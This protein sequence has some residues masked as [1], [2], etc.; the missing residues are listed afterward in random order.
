MN[1][2][3]SHV[4]VKCP[5]N[6]DTSVG[7]TLLQFVQI[8]RIIDRALQNYLYPIIA[9]YAPGRLGQPPH[10]CAAGSPVV[11]ATRIRP[12]YVPLC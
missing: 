12:D 5:L 3:L 11:R 2:E 4:P 1:S 9:N 6:S 7:K 8:M 10:A